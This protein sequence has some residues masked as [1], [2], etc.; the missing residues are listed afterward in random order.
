METIGIGQ[1][2]V[3]TVFSMTVVFLVL[4][5]ISFLID[6]LRIIVE[7]NE[8]KKPLDVVETIEDKKVEKL[9]EDI[10]EDNISDE[11]L[12]AVISAAVAASMGLSLPEINIKQIKRVDSGWKDTARSEQVLKNI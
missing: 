2:I 5:G 9:E 6:L 1:S 3:I 10:K 4:L 12:V 7:K 11:E 8:S